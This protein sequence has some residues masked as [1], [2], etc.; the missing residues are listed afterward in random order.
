[1]SKE[2]WETL[3]QLQL[4]GFT[5]KRGKAWHYREDAQGDEP[6]HYAGAIPVADVRRRLFHWQAVSAP[7]SATFTDAD[8]NE[9]TVTDST[10]QA[11][12]RPDTGAIL[13][14]F[15][16]GYTIHQYDE[17]LIHNVETL[18]DDD[19][20]IGS[21]GLLENGGVAYVQIEMPENIE[22]PEGEIFRPYILATTSLNGKLAT[23]YSSV[24]QRVVCDNTLE[25][26]LTE[27]D[28]QVKVKH[29]KYSQLRIASTRD[30]LRIMHDS[31]DAMSE[32]IK[33]LCETEVSGKLFVKFL[34]NYVPIPDEDGRP[35]TM[36]QRKQDDMMSL[37]TTDERVSPWAG[38]AWGV[39]NMVNTYN[40]HLTT[41]HKGTKRDERNIFATA[42][43][44]IWEADRSALSMLNSMLVSV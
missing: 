4:I 5:D 39:L 10:R 31:A 26:A 36:A 20:Q 7:V 30:V 11:I 6:N 22:T 29:S 1:M 9:H 43:G 16:D 38:T 21:A 28:A 32:E 8:G 35:K 33:R 18:L 25:C 41:L 42:T 3:N 27:K 17:W 40:Q 15:K 37:Y 19:L 24:I 34:D 14:L 44:K 23:T 13:G 2:T 12:I